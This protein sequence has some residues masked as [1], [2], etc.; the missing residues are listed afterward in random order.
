MMMTL[1]KISV[2]TPSFNQGNFI[3]RTIQSVLGQNYP[4]LEYL[5]MDGGSSDGTLEI[6]QQ[7]QAH[8]R[9]VSEPDGGQ[10]AAI[11]KGFRQATGDI[12]CWLNADDEFMPGALLQVADYF[13]QHPEAKLVYG[14]AE[15]IDQAGRSYG[16]RGNVKA[17]NFTELVSQGDFIVQPAA[18]WRAE[19]LAEVGLLDE[20]L[21]YCLD[22]EYW[23]RVA[24]KYPLHYLPVSLAR[25]RFH[26]QAKTTQASLRRMQ[27]IEAVA[28]RYGSPTIPRR[29]RAERTATYLAETL[30]QARLGCWPQAAHYW[31]LTTRQFSPSLR[32]LPHLLARA[33]GPGS[34]TQ[35]RLYYDLL[36]TRF[37]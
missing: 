32:V 20:S 29:F 28:Q 6:L 4:R 25:E 7:Y 21:R 12:V 22:Y 33:L 1:L 30:H 16:R 2:V 31:K 34:V 3:E 23:L 15:T 5:V 10:A 11:N 26:P 9:W 14:N 19:L 17:T 13:S 36:R 35:L 27:E 18:F 8:L 24:Q 37:R